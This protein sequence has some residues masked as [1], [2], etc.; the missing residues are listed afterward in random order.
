MPFDLDQF[1]QEVRS[2][3]L[4]PPN[5]IVLD[6]RLQTSFPRVLEFYADAMDEVELSE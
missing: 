3:R 5:K 2:K 1:A 6:L 4:L